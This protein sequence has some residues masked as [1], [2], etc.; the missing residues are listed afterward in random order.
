[1]FKTVRGGG[2]R[3]LQINNTYPTN[4]MRQIHPEKLTR[5]Q[6]L[7]KV[8][9]FYRTRRFV[10]DSQALTACSCHKSDQSGPFPPSH[11]LKI[12]FNIIPP[13]TPKPSNWSNSLRSSHQNHVYT[14]HLSHTCYM[15]S[16]LILPDLITTQISVEYRS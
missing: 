13:C 8:H 10:T 9:A 5:P 12:H 7:E 16:H 14:S 15:H 4:S 1:M 6:P 11:F 2:R 3:Y